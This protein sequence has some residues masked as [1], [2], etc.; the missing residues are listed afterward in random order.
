MCPHDRR[1]IIATNSFSLFKKD[2]NFRSASGVPNQGIMRD[3]PNQFKERKKTTSRRAFHFPTVESRG[4]RSNFRDGSLMSSPW[5]QAGWRSDVDSP[6]IDNI[7]LMHDI[8]KLPHARVCG[9]THESANER[10]DRRRFN[11][12]RRSTFAARH[13]TQSC[14][15]VVVEV[16]EELDLPRR[17]TMEPDV[18][19]Q[20]YRTRRYKASRWTVDDC[21]LVLCGARKSNGLKAMALK[22]LAV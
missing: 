22:R 6:E 13:Q 7:F 19:L 3:F 10:R 5:L 20:R 12:Y 4:I 21:H 15:E 18:A 11:V 14:V 2:N 1:Y 16:V 9:F 17:P 8:W